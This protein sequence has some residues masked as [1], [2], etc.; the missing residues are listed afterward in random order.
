[1]NRKQ[2]QQGVNTMKYTEKLLWILDKPGTTIHNQ[3]EKYRENIAFVHSLGLKCDCV[4]WSKLDLASP[5]SGEILTAIGRFCEE[6]HW[7]ARGWYTR[8]FA[9]PESAWYALRFADAKEGFFSGHREV[10]SDCGTPVQIVS[11]KAFHEWTV[12]PQGGYDCCLVP[13]GFRTACMA[14]DRDDVDFCWAQDK[15]KY[16]ATQYFHIYPRHTVAHLAN[17]G[18]FCY[19]VQKNG[20]AQPQQLQRMH[21]LGGALPRLAEIFGELHIALPDCYLASELPESG[22]AGATI[23]ETWT[24]VG[25]QHILVHR[26]TAEMLLRRKALTS[27]MLMPVP[28]VDAFPAG[29]D[30]LETVPSL[31]PAKEVRAELLRAYTNLKS[32]VRPRRVI[33][34]KDALKLLRQAKQTRKDDFRKG[35]SKAGAETAAETGCVPLI[36]YYRIADGGH[37]SDEYELL[38]CTRTVE[39]T[40]DMQKRMASEELLQQKPQGMVFAVCPDGDTILLCTD[41]TVVRFS[42]EAP[43]IL[44]HWPG[45]P[46]FMA[47]ALQSGEE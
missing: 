26:D 1:M 19:T 17:G 45:L 23:A 11:V 38:S 40:A 6:H 20:E 5:R 44:A 14:S 12:A 41:G 47:E 39:A 3:D 32:T 8:T 15:G 34:E 13:E 21:D 42:H 36:P 2:A 7:R 35:L 37:L 16:E 29:Y 18:S 46:S 9:E 22:F 25:A 30:V 4:G 28:V 24:I 10:L 43:E 33:P 31:P 27:S